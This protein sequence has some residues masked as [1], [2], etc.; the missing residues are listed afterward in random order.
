MQILDD[1]APGAL[2]PEFS[3][4]KGSDTHPIGHT[5]AGQV[6]RNPDIRRRQAAAIT[7]QG[8]VP[9]TLLLYGFSA[10]SGPDQCHLT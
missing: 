5:R 6:R 2:T 4:D 1:A 10:F 8:A 9:T 7:S 3:I